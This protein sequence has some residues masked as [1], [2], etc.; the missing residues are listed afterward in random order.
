VADQKKNWIL[1][2]KNLM[3]MHNDPKKVMG[4]MGEHMSGQI[5]DTI[6]N[7][8]DPANSPTTLIL[9]NRFPMRQNMQFYDVLRASADA[10]KGITVG[11]SN[12]NPLVWTGI[13]L[14]SITYEVGE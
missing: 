4:L 8:K 1:S 9:K 12:N 10:K 5:R 6:V 14:R 13:M 7:L 11:G 2:T 3:Q